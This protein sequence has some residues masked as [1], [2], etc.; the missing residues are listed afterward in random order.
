MPRYAFGATPEMGEPP[1]AEVG[2]SKSPAA[3]PA[4]CVA[5]KEK[6]GSKG[7][8]AY[9]QCVEGEGNARATMIFGVV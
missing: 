6:A 8:P 4:T 3:I 9:F 2:V 5:W 7:R 1:P